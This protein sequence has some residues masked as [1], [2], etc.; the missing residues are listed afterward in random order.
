MNFKPV[1]AIV[2]V[3][4][5]NNHALFGMEVSQTI[6]LEISNQTNK[7]IDYYVSHGGR[8][9][10]RWLFPYED[11]G[12]MG[13]EARTPIHF[14][15]YKGSFLITNDNRGKDLRLT[16]SNNDAAKKWSYQGKEEWTTD[17]VTLTRLSISSK[18]GALLIINP[19]GSPTL[20]ER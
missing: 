18:K 8:I 10:R 17:Y 15:T 2:A 1:I 11:S 9:E 19:D 20:K 7:I 13:I 4:L 14:Y 5:L 3:I 6:P 16:L 12:A